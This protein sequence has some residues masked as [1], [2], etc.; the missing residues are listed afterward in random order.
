MSTSEYI[1]A[2]ELNQENDQWP[3]KTVFFC[4]ILQKKNKNFK[5]LSPFYIA[6]DIGTWAPLP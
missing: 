1:N 2:G 4:E 3:G 5:Q 6:T